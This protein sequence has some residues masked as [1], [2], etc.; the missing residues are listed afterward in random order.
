MMV[1]DNF[2]EKHRETVQAT[3]ECVE[4]RRWN[5]EKKNYERTNKKKWKTKSCSKYYL[6]VDYLWHCYSMWRIISNNTL[7]HL[8]S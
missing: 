4:K 5:N 1:E 3:S 8:S 7:S 2:N 6:P